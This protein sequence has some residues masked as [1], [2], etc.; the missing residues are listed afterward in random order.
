MEHILSAREFDFIKPG[1]KDF[2]IGFDSEMDRL[3]YECGG[4]GD[5]YCWGRYMSIYT[6]RGV[7]SKKPYARIYIRDDSLIL[8]MYFSNID[9]H[10]GY[11]GSA[12]DY[13]KKAF[14]GDYGACGHCHNQKEDGACMH[15]KTYTIDGK[16]YE[17][18][19]GFAFWFHELTVRRKRA[20]HQER[21][22]YF[23]RF[24]YIYLSFLLTIFSG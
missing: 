13:I 3:G 7:K 18:C 6:K 1:D 8:R 19:D 15:R 16:Q 20:L 17:L 2:I 12:P 4:I 23:T 14:T 11:I 21:L 22:L 24:G 5:G 9:K 10:S